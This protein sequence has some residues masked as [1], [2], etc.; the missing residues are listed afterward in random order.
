MRELLGVLQKENAVFPPESL[1]ARC[2]SRF[3]E[4]AQWLP[5]AMPR[6]V[7]GESVP[8]SPLLVVLRSKRDPKAL[9]SSKCACAARRDAAR[10]WSA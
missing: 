3:L 1:F 4:V 7:L 6:S 8:P 10:D 9:S 2:S 5:V